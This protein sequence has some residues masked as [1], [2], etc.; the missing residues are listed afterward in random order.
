MSKIASG[1]QARIR[2]VVFAGL[3][4]LSLQAHTAPLQLQING[5]NTIGAR[6]APLLVE[7]MLQESGAT[8]IQLQL[9]P[10]TQ[11]HRIS[12]IS[13]QAEPIEISLNAHGSSTGFTALIDQTGQIAAA[14]RPIKDSEVE[15]LKEAG[16]MRSKAAEQIIGLDGL[17][18]IVHPENPISTLDVEQIAR[19]FSGQVTDWAQ[20]GGQQGEIRLHARDGN[21]GT[22]ETFRDLV[23]TPRQLDLQ[24][25]ARR[26]ESNAALSAAVS[27]DRNA[28]GFVGLASVEQA[29]ALAVSAG[30]SRAMLPSK[31]LV[32]TEDYPLSRRLYMYISPEESNPLA[33]ALITF[34][35]SHAGQEIVDQVGFVGQNITA[36][37][38][39]P[40]PYMPDEYRT[41]AEEAH[42]LSFNIRFTEGSAR[43]DNKAH[44]DIDRLLAYLHA[45][46]KTQ[47][48]VVL[49]GFGDPR[50]RGAELLSRL[51]AMT[52]RAALV[53]HGIFVK[54]TIGIGDDLPVAANT[55]DDGRFKNRR[56]ELWVY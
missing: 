9:N 24:T 42:R 11:E 27:S 25:D 18:V 8:D 52:V 44:Q 45:Q 38:V 3:A 34:T 5:S 26:Y 55:D 54:D 32:A 19:I 37:Q 2:M 10:D 15:A 13:A 50:Q 35:Q 20:L 22:W 1:L 33:Q 7:G 41:L 56:V 28:I 4:C 30:D 36:M 47:N 16:D 21:S 46:G 14:S 43:L 23:L 51:R 31:E 29:K 40:Q 6:L 48:K 39:T 12:A 53:G 17:A 49:V